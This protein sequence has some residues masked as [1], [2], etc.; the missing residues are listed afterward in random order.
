MIDAVVNISIF[1]DMSRLGEKFTEINCNINDIYQYHRSKILTIG[2]SY[3][4]A[5]L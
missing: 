4:A 3:A 2:N 1:V 5:A